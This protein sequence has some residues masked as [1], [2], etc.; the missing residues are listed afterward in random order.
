MNTRKA[1]ASEI[2]VAP[3]FPLNLFRPT[4]FQA[5]PG[6]SLFLFC[7]QLFFFF[8]F[9]LRRVYERQPKRKKNFNPKFYNVGVV[10]AK[11]TLFHILL[12]RKSLI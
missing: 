7:A 2:R 8:S 5:E 9:L 6:V 12:H 3:S 10:G 1:K 4:L 11:R